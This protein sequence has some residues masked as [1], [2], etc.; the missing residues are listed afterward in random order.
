MTYKQLLTNN[1]NIRILWLAGLFSNLGS[2]FTTVALYSLLL[3]F[4]ASS[5]IVAALAAIHMIP[6][7][8]LAPI[9]GVII[10]KIEAKKLILSMIILQMIATFFMLFVKDVSLIWLLFTLVFFKMAGASFLF[11]AQMALVPHLVK[12]EELRYANDINAATW[13]LTFVLG[14]ALGG[15]AVEY[16]GIK[17]AFIVDLFT[18]FIA[19]LLILRLRAPQEIEKST[20]KIWLL[21]KEGFIYITAQP[22]I[23]HLIL[24]HA[25]VGFTAFDALITLL[26]RDYYAPEV[27]EP[28]AIGFMQAIKALGLFIGPF[29]FIKFTNQKKLLSYLFFA[30]GFAIFLWAFLE[31]DYYLGFMGLFVTGLFITSIWSITYS[32]LQSNIDKAYYGRVLAYNDMIFLSVNAITSMLIGVLASFGYSLENVTSLFG[33]LF[34]LIGIYYLWVKANYF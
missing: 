8:I 18:F 33:I 3:E 5:M 14:M 32:M 1:S 28:L 11:T 19:F 24:L 12:D 16:L 10:D 6:G 13:S 2:W 4:N 9:S 27:S 30:Q 29:I 31:F 20:Q 26:A 15:L 23:L 34:L 17:S 22:K 21:M 25:S 7:A